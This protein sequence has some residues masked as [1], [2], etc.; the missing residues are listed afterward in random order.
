MSDKRS[1]YA[2]QREQLREWLAD[3]RL[4]R[5]LRESCPEVDAAPVAASCEIMAE[6]TWPAAGQVRL[7]RPRPSSLPEVERPVYVLLMPASTGDA[8]R[9]IP[10][11]R[12][13]IPAT[14]REWRT[15]LGL[16]PLR[17]LCFWNLRICDPAGLQ[18]SWPV[19]ALT[20][21]KQSEVAAILQKP[22]HLQSVCMRRFGP[23]LLHP[24][25]P[26]HVYL[27]E[28]HTLMNDL[29]LGVGETTQGVFEYPF[30]E[31]DGDSLRAAESRST[32]STEPTHSE[33]SPEDRDSPDRDHP[34]N[35]FDQSGG[36]DQGAGPDEDSPEISR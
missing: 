1:D 23:P 28:E 22:N 19:S 4:D 14:P 2:F 29:C 31:P 36:S 26:R 35:R 25:D 9:L 12:Y 34:D 15:G 8:L 30:F 6:F 3:D 17:V 33:D 32:Y 18:A 24:L 20:E 21:E 13:A 16:T 7:L 10:F 27:Q 11:G 5:R